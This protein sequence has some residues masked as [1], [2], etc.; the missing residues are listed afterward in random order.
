MISSRTTKWEPTLT[1]WIRRRSILHQWIPFLLSINFSLSYITKPNLPHPP[2]EG[3]SYQ[4]IQTKPTPS[5]AK[6]W[7]TNY[8]SSC[9]FVRRVQTRPLQPLSRHFAS[10]PIV[11]DELSHTIYN[12]WKA[13]SL[14]YV[15]L[16]CVPML[17]FLSIRTKDINKF[18]TFCED[19]KKNFIK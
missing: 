13:W 17:N 14:V 15:C 16:M 10:Q 1:K 19:L 6:K 4:L 2:L 7:R 8:S 18:N 12:Q 3:T 11:L 5:W 9:P